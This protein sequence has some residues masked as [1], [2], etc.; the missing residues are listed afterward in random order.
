MMMI[1]IPQVI[2]LTI[3]LKQTDIAHSWTFALIQYHNILYH[4]AWS[5]VNDPQKS[6]FKRVSISYS[7]NHF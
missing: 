6:L 7:V 4:M 3:E 5:I 1:I 2:L